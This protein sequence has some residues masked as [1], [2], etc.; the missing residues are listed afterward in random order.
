CIFIYLQ[1]TLTGVLNGLGKQGILLRNTVIGSI[2]RIAVICVLLPVFGIK[3]YIIG[4][5]VSLLLTE[6]MDLIEINKMTGLV[7]DL[8]EWIVKP[9][10]AGVL[11][12]VAGRYI[13]HFFEIFSFGARLTTLLSV[14][15]DVMFAVVLLM[16]VGV[17]ELRE[18]LSMAGL[19]NMMK[20]GKK[21]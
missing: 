17:F 7:I 3:A 18:L 13:Y 9:A 2:I 19:D 5:T 10:L 6:C 20:T 15:V 4:L 1:Q 8:R 16:L 14:A 21:M 11:M 12:I